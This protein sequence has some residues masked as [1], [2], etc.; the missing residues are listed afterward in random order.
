MG[1]A[2][3]L[4]RKPARMKDV[5]LVEPVTPLV[6]KPKEQ[7]VQLLTV[8]FVIALTLAEYVSMGHSAGLIVGGGLL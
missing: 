2:V 3:L 1:I 6:V 8:G 5:Q 7:A 4:T